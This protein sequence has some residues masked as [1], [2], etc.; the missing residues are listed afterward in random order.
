MKSANYIEREKHICTT[1]GILP[2]KEFTYNGDSFIVGEVIIDTPG[3]ICLDPNGSNYAVSQSVLF[4][5]IKNK[6]KIVQ[7]K[8]FSITK[9][10]YDVIKAFGFRYASRD[11]GEEINPVK[12]WAE[13]PEIV[14]VNER[15]IYADKKLSLGVP[16]V[17]NFFKSIHL[18]DCI[19]ID[20]V[21]VIEE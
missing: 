16:C 9:R 8:T 7:K 13:K 11:M 6:D 17:Y 15:Y 4:E 12:L 5:L 18:G 19:C 3:V 2:N 20:E 1:L 10:E 14:E 21:E